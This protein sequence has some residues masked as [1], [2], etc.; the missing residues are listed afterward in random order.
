MASNSFTSTLVTGLA[1]VPVKVKAPGKSRVI[2]TYA[3]LD[4]G[5]NTT[6]CTEELMQ[7]LGIKGRKTNLSLTTVQSKNAAVECRLLNLEVFDLKQENQID[8]PNVYSMHK[9]PVSSADIAT[10]QDID[11]WPHLKG[12]ELTAIDADVGLLIGCDVPEALQPQ[13]IRISQNGGP[14]ATRTLLGWTVNGPLGKRGNNTPTANHIRADAELSHQFERFCN[15]EL[16][17][18][19][20]D[21]QAAMSRNDEKALRAMEETIQLK[22]SH[23]EMALPWKNSPP[24]LE[25]NRTMAEHRLNLLK[26]RLQKDES[27]FQRYKAFIDDLISKGHARKIPSSEEH[28]S[29]VWYLPHHPVYHPQKPNKVRVV[30]DCSAK[31]RGTSLNDQ[32]LQGPDLT[33]SLVGVLTR[34]RQEP[35]ALMADIEAMFYQVKVRPSDRNCLRFLWWPSGDFSRTPEEY[36]MCVHLFGGTSS[37]SCANFALR[38]TATDNEKDFDPTTVNT[39]LSNFY[40][41][42]C[43]KSVATTA[44][45]IRLTS[46]LRQLLARGGFRLTKWLSN[47]KAVL[48]SVPE[49]E[50]AATVKNLDFD[51]NLTERA[52]G[53]QWNVQADTF[54][55]KITNKNKPST[56]RG[57]L[58]I[59]SS[60]YDPLGFVSPVV[61]TAKMILQELC[62]KKLKWDDII[63]E[64]EL[65]DWETWL[66]DLPKLEQFAIKRCFKPQYLTAI[67]SCEL[68]HF[69]DASELGYGAASY[70]RLVTE[71]GQV[72]CALVMAKSRLTPLKHVTI[73][74]LELTAAVLAT[75]L[76]R[77]I[78]KE[79]AYPIDKS[80]FWTDSTCVL[81]YI[82]NQEKRFQVFVANRVTKI[83]SQSEETQWRYVDTA[84]NP[85]DEASRGMTV[86][87]LLQNLRW[88]NGPEFLHQT[89]DAWPQ[90]PADF[91]LIA[92]NDPEVKREITVCAT[93]ANPDPVTEIIE[94]FSSWNRL[95]R[96]AAWILR[97]KSKLQQATARR[98]ANDHVKFQ[99]VSEIHPI[100]VVELQNAE[101]A[102]LRHVQKRCFSEELL[103]LK[104]VNP[105]CDLRK[106]IAV[107][108]G[109]NI[110]KLDPILMDGLIRVG[111]RLHRAP[112]DDE[113][114]HP[115]CCR[116]SITS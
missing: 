98:K 86:D 113:T 15:F 69:S 95:K 2:E 108:K 54:N 50:R 107:Q 29:P 73:P 66:K 94:R 52:L 56:R 109:S 106:K 77:M 46:Q 68:H 114:R 6:F 55:F 31:W 42:D 81:R 41:D 17:D 62:R 39:V 70:L 4:N 78:R 112:I 100:E 116:R 99:A 14:Y 10:R 65:R 12:I 26:R 47:N 43:L 90:Q 44:K 35:V 22:A 96:I 38:K 91:G 58:S 20:Q 37:P 88:T 89:E 16:N 67:K 53:V 85:A 63:P 1:I 8:L 101:S 76:D 18:S 21:G 23:Y 34:F 32:L 75:R 19:E 11:R 13:D 25:N 28:S 64:K 60:V 45:A 80:T 59:V 92:D 61:L 102:L 36:Q 110:Y 71:T 9:L 49:S 115:L 104:P 74:R 79:I 72:H 3:F 93:E 87:V 27:T 33:N 51:E 82:R 84:S 40:V 57:I 111:G 48:Q 5:S 103:I 30:F 83:L 24:C 105:L 97:Y 7:K